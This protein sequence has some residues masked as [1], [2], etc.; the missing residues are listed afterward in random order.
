MTSQRGLQRVLFVDD[1]AQVL[2]G[3]RSGLR[4]Q[5]QTLDLSFAQ[6]AD[7]GLA[8]L[9]RGSYD[10]VVADM[11]MPSMDGA[12][13]LRIVME[14]QP[15]VVRIVLSGYTDRNNVLRALGIAHQFLSKPCPTDTLAD[16]LSR[17]A[18]LRGLIGDERLRRFMSRLMSLPA[19]QSISDQL[20]DTLILPGSS[21]TSVL[22]IV[23]QDLALSAKLLQ[24]VNSSAP[25]PIK[26]VG[27]LDDAVARMDRDTLRALALSSCLVQNVE[28]SASLPGL[29]LARLHEHA[30]LS[31]RIA[32]RLMTNTADGELAFTTALL[33]NAGKLVL[34][35]WWPERFALVVEA[36]RSG[37]PPREAEQLLF[38]F[39]H[40][41]V[42][43]YLL[44]LWGLPASSV[45]AV[46]FHH[47]PRPTARG[48][49]TRLDVV[50]AVHVAC[51]LAD[52]MLLPTPGV[53]EPAGLERRSIDELGLWDALPGWRLIAEEEANLPASL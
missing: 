12:S 17:A 1:D 21:A 45:E 4:R 6:G 10:V 40:A 24:I 49:A 2:Q 25:G 26:P 37:V 23:E 27:T 35:L 46:A 14:Q 48:G 44:G 31:A 50:T 13:F 29:S 19:E 3:L 20:V 30:L 34:W 38:G 39:T 52:E 22:R 15:D 47:E 7:A 28:Q 16:V 18:A 53:T 41:E 43:A 9:S 8:A 32:R 5:R 42:G 33:A 51:A 36:C 11:R